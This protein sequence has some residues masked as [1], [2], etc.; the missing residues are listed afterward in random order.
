MNRRQQQIIL[1]ISFCFVFLFLTSADVWA[2]GDQERRYPWDERPGLCFESEAN[3]TP[4]CEL[5]SWSDWD[6]TV[7]RVVSLYLAADFE[8]LERALHELLTSRKTYSNGASTA[9]AAYWAFRTA[10]PGPGAHEGNAQLIDHWI[11]RFPDSPFAVFAQARYAYASAWNARGGG[12]SGSVI[13]E[14]WELFR[15]RLHEAEKVLLAAPESLKNTPLWHNLM[16]AIAQ[17]LGA[18]DLNPD[19]V[20]KQ[21][22]ALW[23]RYY[24]FYEVRLTRLVPRWGGSWSAVEKFVDHWSSNSAK[25]EG[26]SLYARLYISLNKQGYTPDQ[27]ELSWNKMRKS[28]DD[29]TDRYPSVEFKNLNAS[30]ACAARDRDAFNQAM[31]KL[32]PSQLHGAAWLNGSSYEA[33]M[34]WSSI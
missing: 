15:I 30:Y 28:L 7:R 19:Q 24:D 1:A 32:T 31:K 13:T 6:M 2:Q 22:V 4:Q 27:M 23:P 16:L 17:D 18:N 5:N 25:T 14:S 26:S 33:C 11:K 10:M 8:L 9:S 3:V 34:R 21:A 29:L 20:F 12:Y